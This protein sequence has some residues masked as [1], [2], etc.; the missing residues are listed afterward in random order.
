MKK[1][2]LFVLV[3]GLFFNCFSQYNLLLLDGSSVQT[4]W[5]KYNSSERLYVYKN[6]KGKIR[7]VEPE[8]IFSIITP[9]NQRQILYKP[10]SIL[11]YQPDEMYSLIQGEIDAI[12]GFKPYN[13]FIV[14][15]LHGA[16][17]TFVPYKLGVNM[18]YSTLLPIGL[19]QVSFFMPLST[20]KLVVPNKYDPKLYK[21]GYIFK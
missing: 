11:S 5:L 12:K 4:N 9:G 3:S 15:L 6:K 1:L 13:P 2:L 14:G 18:F 16:V 8:F 10:D 17:F 20:K 19:S 21:K 7:N